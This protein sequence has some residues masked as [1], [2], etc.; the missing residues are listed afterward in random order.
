MSTV[1]KVLIH[2]DI[3]PAYVKAKQVGRFAEHYYKTILVPGE[4]DTLPFANFPQAVQTLPWLMFNSQ[5]L[6]SVIPK[7]QPT[8]LVVAAGHLPEMA[9]WGQ[10]MMALSTTFPNVNCRCLAYTC[11]PQCPPNLWIQVWPGMLILNQ[12]DVVIGGAGY[13]TVFECQ[14]LGKPLIAFAWPRQYDRQQYRGQRWAKLVKTSQEAIDAVQALLQSP[15]NP[16]P[17]QPYR[18]GIGDAIAI[19]DKTYS[20]P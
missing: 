19:I 9:F 4:G 14:A 15:R 5:E 13:N 17:I 10:F 8:I 1:P 2:R 3:D 6:P 11:P 12:A 7:G 18:N 16:N 20:A